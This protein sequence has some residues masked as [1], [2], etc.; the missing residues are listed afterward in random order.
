MLVVKKPESSEW[1]GWRGGPPSLTDLYFTAREFIPYIERFI[2][3]Y[4]MYLQPDTAD[5]VIMDFLITM[6]QYDSLKKFDLTMQEVGR[7]AL[8]KGWVFRCLNKR[9]L[10]RLKSRS[11]IAKRTSSM[12]VDEDYRGTTR[13]KLEPAA[14]DNSEWLHSVDLARTRIIALKKRLPFEMGEVIDAMTACGCVTKQAAA[15][16]GVEPAYIRT[17]IKAIREEAVVMGLATSKK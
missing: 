11:R 6:I 9:M 15:S 7:P 10:S 17:Q 4:A 5:D 3:R 8:F 2:A 14:P 12:T 1:R 16:L 13:Y